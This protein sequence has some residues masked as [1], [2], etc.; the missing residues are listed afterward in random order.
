MTRTYNDMADNLVVKQERDISPSL[1]L[2]PKGIPNQQCYLTF[3]DEFIVIDRDIRKLLKKP[4]N[5]RML[6]SHIY[7]KNLSIIEQ[8][9]L[10]YTI[11]WKIIHLTVLQVLNLANLP[12]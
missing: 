11:N 4:L 1:S 12:V 2:S 5:Y 9:T 8:F 6:E 10:D 7:H 3:N